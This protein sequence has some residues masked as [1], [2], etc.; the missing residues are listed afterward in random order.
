M[1][2]MPRSLPEFVSLLAATSSNWISVRRRGAFRPARLPHGIAI[3]STQ[4][5]AKPKTTT[6]RRNFDYRNDFF[7]LQVINGSLADVDLSRQLT[8]FKQRRIVNR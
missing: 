2:A 4:D 7:P 8:T 5:V 6:T 1:L 3:Q